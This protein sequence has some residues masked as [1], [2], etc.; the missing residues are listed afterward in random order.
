MDFFGD[1][2]E[3]PYR[4][5]ELKKNYTLDE[6]RTQYKKMVLRYHPDKHARNVEK[7]KEFNVLTKCYK[8]L[9]ELYKINETYGS[10]LVQGQN[11]GQNQG[12]DSDFF[13][14]RQGFEKQCDD[15]VYNPTNPL[16]SKFNI[17]KFNEQYERDKYIDPIASKGYDDF[18]KDPNHVDPTKVKQY[19]NGYDDI[20]ENEDPSPLDGVDMSDCYELGGKNQNLG[21]T[22]P[23]AAKL[24]FMDYKIAYTS[25]KIIDEAKVKPRIEYK[26]LE[27]LNAE[28]AKP[29]HL[30]ASEKLRLEQDEEIRKKDEMERLFRLQNQRNQLQ[31]HFIRTQ[32][33][34]T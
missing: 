27:E 22:N 30:H 11:Q 17:D 7:T 25:P 19:S 32:K 24:H 18:M 12:Q 3:Y 20:A 28:R 29:I 10:A 15:C 23:M 33:T 21:R 1:D 6:L 14:L 34:L 2:R 16:V 31:E 13:S 9:L 4:L 26:S 5:F 8:Y